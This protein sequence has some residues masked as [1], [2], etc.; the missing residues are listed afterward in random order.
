[1]KVDL[2]N[3]LLALK[4][5]AEKGSFT[6][7]AGE[8]GVTTSA[9]SQ[10]IKQLETQLGS[11]LLN[12]TT[13]STSLTELGEYFLQ[14]YQ[15]AL[16]QL[17]EAIEE[18]GSFSGKPF[19]TLRLNL[20]RG[21]WPCVI[22]PVLAGFQKQYPDIVVELFFQDS[23]AD[24]ARG[25]FDAG[26][27]PSEMTAEGMTAIR[28]SPPLRFVVA[29]SPDYFGR[30]GIPQHPKDLTRHN[31][32]LSRF[33]EGNIYRRWEFE[34]GDHA[35]SV[36]VSGNVLVNDTLLVIECARRGLGLVYSTDDLVE[37]AVRRGELVLCL[38]MF[39]PRSDGY[40]LYYPNLYQVS[41]KLRA[42]IDYL[43]EKKRGSRFG[44]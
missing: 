6:A 36:S 13:R 34:D 42:F 38:E 44:E 4:L 33:G 28:I 10:T 12:R 2:L 27:R 1:M 11:V 5:V 31:C 37:E 22:A 8:M 41:P 21:S 30:R 16:A 40:Y 43:K 14:Q 29:G 15:P 9:V 3:G 19:G 39:A 17:L 26:V 32:I 35:F 23:F 25:G 20:P 7:A 18:L 24:L